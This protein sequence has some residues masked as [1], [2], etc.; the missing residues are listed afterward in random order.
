M[1][2]LSNLIGERKMNK[3]TKTVLILIIILVLL[4]AF[5]IWN[6]MFLSWD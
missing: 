4:F 2:I 6:N 1:L 5:F 3:R